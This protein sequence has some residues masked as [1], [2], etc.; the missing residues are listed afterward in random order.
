MIDSLNIE[1]LIMTYKENTA[2]FEELY[3]NSGEDESAI[4][5][6][7]LT[8]NVFLQQYLE[9]HTGTRGKALVI[10]CGLGDDAMALDE[11]GFD[12]VAIDISPSAL[13]WAQKRFPDAT[14]LFEEHNIFEMPQKYIGYFDFVFEA[15][16]IQSLPLRYRADMI[17]AISS[18]L[19]PAGKLLVVA[20][21]KNEGEVYK[22]PPYP[23]LANELGLFK[24]QGLK[25][26]SFSIY[27]EPSGP[28]SLK[29]VALYQR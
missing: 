1:E 6:A 4:P 12:T 19:A 2:W 22:G 5:W 7:K 16:T 29:Y 9:N 13:E 18:V 26:L 20:H 24:M 21:A 17:K 8:V 14:I 27:E 25:E 28:S 23:V 10:G 11:A 3:K 15:F